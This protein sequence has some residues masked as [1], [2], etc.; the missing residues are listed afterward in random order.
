PK[1]PCRKTGRRGPTRTPG[2][3]T[4]VAACASAFSL[5]ALN[6]GPDRRLGRKLRAAHAH[7]ATRILPQLLGLMEMTNCA[8]HGAEVIGREAFCYV[9][10]IERRGLDRSENLCGERHDLAII[11]GLSGLVRLAVHI[12]VDLRLLGIR[13]GDAFIMLAR[14]A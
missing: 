14:N 5:P 10:V 12:I 8:C 1:T 4:T 11:S 9:G 2:P 13:I 7:A 3:N 6:S